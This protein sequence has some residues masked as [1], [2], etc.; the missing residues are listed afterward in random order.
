MQHGR[1]VAYSARQLKVHERN[2]SNHDLKL[3]Y[4]V[5]PL[6]I[7]RHYLY[8]VHVDVYNNHKSLQYV[9]T[10][11]DFNLGQR[12]WLDLLNDYDMSV[13]YH[14]VKANMVVDSLSRITMGSVSHVEKSKKD[15]VKYVHRFARLCV[16]FEDSPNGSFS[17]HHNTE[18]SFVVEVNSK[19][20]FD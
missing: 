6:K 15:L 17:V 8:G 3:A 5:F 7:W 18:S 9:F 19:Q 11:K 14:P 16:R 12:R 4:V 2:Y 20:H 10:L 13:L 1:V